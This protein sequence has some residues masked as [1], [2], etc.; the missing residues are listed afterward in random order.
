[1]KLNAYSYLLILLLTVGACSNTPDPSDPAFDRDKPTPISVSSAVEEG[2]SI[3]EQIEKKKL[4]VRALARQWKKSGRDPKHLES[5]RLEFNHHMK[6]QEKRKAL[7]KLEEMLVILKEPENIAS[8]SSPSENDIGA[9]IQARMQEIQKLIPEFVKA[10]GDAF[11]IE[12]FLKAF[13]K[14]A[15]SGKPHQGLEKL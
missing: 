2:M 9:Q 15:K 4:E 10:G 5:L 14:L 3:A 1:M 8:S 7:I 13:E 12:S 11:Q 6:R